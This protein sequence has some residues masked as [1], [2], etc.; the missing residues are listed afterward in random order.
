MRNRKL[1]AAELVE[2]FRGELAKGL[3][4]IDARANAVVNCHT[5]GRHTAGHD[6]LVLAHR[7]DAA[8]EN[9]K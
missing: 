4:H 9:R 6:T 5:H 8:L 1:E 3:S 2:A 7:L